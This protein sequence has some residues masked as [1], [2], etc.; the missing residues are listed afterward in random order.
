MNP[1][2]TGAIPLPLLIVGIGLLGF[3]TVLTYAPFKNKF[4]YL[5]PKAASLA[6]SNSFLASFDGNPNTP[7][8]FLDSVE[9]AQFD[10]AV[11]SRDI[12][13][14]LQLTPFQA[15]HGA[16]CS[17][18]IDANGMM[19]THHDSGDYH[20][21]VFKCRD[22]IM[23]TIRAGLHGAPDAA[24]S[25][26][27]EE[28][29]YAV[30]YLTPNQLVDFSQG[31]VVISW[32]M[33][34]LRTST[35]DWIDVWVTPFEDNLQL[36]LYKWLP[37]LDGEP[38]RAIHINMNQFNGLTV[39]GGEQFNNFTSVGL[40]ECWWCTLED[41]MTTS[42]KQRSKFELRLSKNHVKFSMPGGQ[43]DVNGQPI[44]NG[45][46]I[47]WIDKTL[48]TP[49]DWDSGVVQF[50][51][52]SYNPSKDCTYNPSTPYKTC[53]ANT[54]HWDNISLSNSTPFT[55][56]K[57][58]RRYIAKGLGTDTDDTV[59]FDRPAL[60]NSFLRF[61]AVGMVEYRLDN[62]QTFLTAPI[63]KASKSI[64]GTR[65]IGVAN[66]YFI[67]IPAGTSSVTFKLS[68]EGWYQGFP[69]IAKDFAI[70]SLTP[71]SMASTPSVSP[72]PVSS[73]SPIKVGDIDGNKKVDIFDYNLLLTNFNR[74]GS[75]IPGDLNSSGKVDIF[76]Y[77]ILLS[78][79]GK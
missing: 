43:L 63:Q 30:I 41:K 47:V 78:N 12:K 35:R 3:L 24:I 9:S 62:N 65:A 38:K 13:N 39:F 33:A 32:D 14:W 75:V 31:E 55:V 1:K 25:Q 8:P 57:A 16:D 72:S 74:T 68:G 20:S 29:G 70:W 26:P 69:L 42:P 58:N 45:Q 40:D 10:V 79:F 2:Q 15:Q 51:H 61:S 23:T 59:T 4:S 49:L 56:I 17:P 50:G 6:A 5:F 67:P 76:D 54:W 11:H 52:H 77:N 22:H 18:P 44:N 37:D 7:E 60:E 21:A 66:N 71:S 64:D 36:P 34:T 73:P 53:Y 46:E 28:D 19:V 27:G 48:S